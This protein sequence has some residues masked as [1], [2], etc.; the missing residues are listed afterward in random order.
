MNDERCR[1][2][3]LPFEPSTRDELKP[4]PR[5]GKCTWIRDDRGASQLALAKSFALPCQRVT[6]CK[7]GHHLSKN[8]DGRKHECWIPTPQ[9]GRGPSPEPKCPHLA[10]PPTE[11]RRTQPQPRRA[12]AFPA[13]SMKSTPPQ[14][15][16]P[17]QFF[18]HVSTACSRGPA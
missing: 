9:P 5:A 10:P 4:R 15:G 12:G 3:N 2:A 7:C 16:G 17:R 11:G 6:R 14:R 18:R 1:D 13:M 8:G